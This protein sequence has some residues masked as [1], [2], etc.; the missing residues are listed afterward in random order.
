MS[1]HLSCSAYVGKTLEKLYNSF[2]ITFLSGHLKKLFKKRYD[3]HKRDPKR[4]V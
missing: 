1:L 2:S 4:E 3:M